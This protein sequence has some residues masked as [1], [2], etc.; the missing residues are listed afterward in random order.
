LRD[1]V[2]LSLGIIPRIL[3]GA[4]E[5]FLLLLNLFHQRRPSLV[6][7]LLSLSIELL[8]QIIHFVV[9]PLELVLLRFQFL[10][11][12]IEIALA[13]VA[14]KDGLST[15]MVPILVPP[16]LVA[17]GPVVLGTAALGAA[18]SAAEG[19]PVWA[20]AA[21][22]NAKAVSV[23][24]RKNLLVM[25]LLDSLERSLDVPASRARNSKA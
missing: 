7:E 21:S 11:Q 16:A 9:Q 20:T 25:R 19:L 24:H 17:V 2:L 14:G 15:L 5:R 4:F 23:K 8:L 22:E 6:V 10:A 13:F 12:G 1:L 3:N 18:G